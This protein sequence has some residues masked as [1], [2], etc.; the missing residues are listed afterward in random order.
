MSLTDDD[1]LRALNSLAIEDDYTIDWVHPEWEPIVGVPVEDRRLY[2]FILNRCLGSAAKKLAPVHGITKV[3]WTK[4]DP[5]R[6][7]LIGDNAEMKEYM[8]KKN[9]TNT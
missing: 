7:F 2:M 5:E 4:L 1:I 8:D 9:E 6:E 3:S